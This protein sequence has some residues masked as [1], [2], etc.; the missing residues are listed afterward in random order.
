MKFSDLMTL[1][2]ASTGFSGGT[3][4]DEM[5][6]MSLTECTG[7]L[8]IAMLEGQIEMQEMTSKYN[9]AMVEAAINAA[10]TGSYDELNTLCENAFG[11]L[12]N[13]IVAIFEKIKKFLSSIIDKLGVQINKVRMTG[14]QMLSRY[15]NSD[16]L[17]KDFKDFTVEGYKFDVKDNYFSDTNIAPSEL[18]AKALPATMPTPDQ[19][20]VDAK[21]AGDNGS[22]TK[23]LESKLTKI[24][25]VDSK[26]RKLA[27]AKALLAG[28]K[29][30]DDWTASVKK[31]LYGEKVTLKYGKEITLDKVKTDLVGADLDAIAQE[32][33]ALKKAVEKDEADVRSA[34]DEFNAE[35]NDSYYKDSNGEEIKSRTDKP[36]PAAYD[37]AT[38]YFNAYLTYYQECTAVITQVKDIRVN[39][40]KAKTKQAKDIFAKMLTYKAPKSN[41][42]DASDFDAIEI[43]SMDI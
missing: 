10:H 2:E 3:I 15:E 36:L 19:F 42:S 12:K 41:N 26:D 14:R 7:A 35:K 4:V 16:M 33:T 8:P 23:A 11:T 40:E 32:Y 27:Y 17:K 25:E 39:Y 6:H 24:S 28:A 21:K 31:D 20:R 34:A 37:M 22:S 29:L 13:K 38:K 43:L 5:P 1:A 9:D 18:I 30:N